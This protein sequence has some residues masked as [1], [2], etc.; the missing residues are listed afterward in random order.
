VAGARTK[1]R[2]VIRVYPKPGNFD[3]ETAIIR[4]RARDAV[5]KMRA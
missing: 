2:V 1:R 3:S 4:E 5:I